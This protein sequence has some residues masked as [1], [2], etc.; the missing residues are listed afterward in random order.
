MEAR[1][2]RITRPDA[3]DAPSPPT[4]LRSPQA[5]PQ[6]DTQLS[7]SQMIDAVIQRFPPPIPVKEFQEELERTQRAYEALTS[8][9]RSTTARPTT[10]QATTESL[11]AITPHLDLLASPQH[12]TRRSTRL[13]SVRSKN[14]STTTGSS[15]PGKG[16]HTRTPRQGEGN[17][18]TPQGADP[19]SPG[20]PVPPGHGSSPDEPPAEPDSPQSQEFFSPRSSASLLTPQRGRNLQRIPTAHRQRTRDS[21]L[22]LNMPCLVPGCNTTIN[23]RTTLL[24]HL[25]DCHKGAD[26]DPQVKDSL[27]EYDIAK[28]E[29]LCQAYRSVN[30]NGTIHGHKCVPPNPPRPRNQKSAADPNRPIQIPIPRARAK[31]INPGDQN[32]PSK[33]QLVGRAICQRLGT[34]L[35]TDVP[36]DKVSLPIIEWRIL[37]A[38]SAQR[39]AESLPDPARQEE[40]LA[41][42]A[43]FVYLGFFSLK[44]AHMQLP[45]SLPNPFLMT[46]LQGPPHP[47]QTGNRQPISRLNGP[48]A[49]IQEVT[50]AA[51]LAAKGK[52]GAAAEALLGCLPA[53]TDDPTTRD[54]IRS[55]FPDRYSPENPDSAYSLPVIPAAPQPTGEEQQT[56]L[57]TT[58]NIIID[59]IH[60]R[61]LGSVGAWD[62]WTYDKLKIAVPKIPVTPDHP[63]IAFALLV[64]CLL[65]GHAQDTPIH[66]FLL[67]QRGVAL[68][69]GPS[70]A[71]GIRPICVVS[72][73]LRIC[74]HVLIA[75]HGRAL[76]SN[77][78][79]LDLGSSQGAGIEALP[80]GLQATLDLNPNTMII[81]LDITNAFNTLSREHLFTMIRTLHEENKLPA[82]FLFLPWFRFL[83]NPAQVVFP[84]NTPLT[85]SLCEGVPQGEPLSPYW[86]DLWISMALEPLRRAFHNRATIAGCHD[87]LF[88]TSSAPEVAV[89]LFLQVQQ[90]LARAHQ[91][92]NT[93]KCRVLLPANLDDDIAQLISINCDIPVQQFSR[94]GLVVA[95]TPIGSVPFIQDHINS[96]KDSIMT[97]CSKLSQAKT[98]LADPVSFRRGIPHHH[99]EMANAQGLIQ[100]LRLCIPSRFDL[101]LRTISVDHTTP[102]A[103]V[104][105]ECVRNTALTITDLDTSPDEDEK[106]T[107]HTLMALP[108]S[109]GGL[110][111]RSLT[112]TAAPASIASWAATGKTVIELFAL[113]LLSPQA[114]QAFLSWKSQVYALP[115]EDVGTLSIPEQDKR[116]MKEIT[117]LIRVVAHENVANRQM[118]LESVRLF[119]PYRPDAESNT[120]SDFPPKIQPACHAAGDLIGVLTGKGITHNGTRAIR[121]PKFHIKLQHQL[122]QAVYSLMQE[123]ISTTLGH[124]NQGIAFASHANR[125]SAAGFTA[126]PALPEHRMSD[127]VFNC[128]FATRGL[129]NL[130][131]PLT[132]G[133]EP[134]ACAAPLKASDSGACDTLCTINSLHCFHCSSPAVRGGRTAGH[135]HGKAAIEHVFSTSELR[136]LYSNSYH[137]QKREPHLS[138]FFS[139]SPTS[140]EPNVNTRADAIALLKSSL[141]APSGFLIDV[142]FVTPPSSPDYASSPS[143]PNGS[144]AATEAE[145][146]KLEHYKRRFDIPPNHRIQ[147]TPIALD[148]FGAAGEGTDKFISLIASQ[149]YP[150]TSYNKPSGEEAVRLNPLRAPFVKR[151][152]QTLAIG[153]FK[154]QAQS[155]YRWVTEGI[156]I[157][158]APKAST[159]AIGKRFFD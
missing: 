50:Q 31:K 73:L 138:Q 62:G 150:P 114:R 84:A 20:S 61:P 72:P 134:F 147:V 45:S 97:M 123:H 125:F 133:Q 107:S 70:P 126:S 71:D 18:R 100:V 142:T 151:L 47:Q 11:S 153:A 16:R 122:S 111:L 68:Q 28:C 76:A 137:G 139:R 25:N 136:R 19:S 24:A 65:R 69:K 159:N 22:Y 44:G 56:F 1:D 146:A 132:R 63:A 43:S 158:V 35:L 55:K 5:I 131:K 140:P 82:P 64:D 95:G 135:A 96:V 81:E 155:V 67:Q 144:K 33:R 119:S 51:V 14:H 128:V 9:S 92:L 75:I 23:D 157:S 59:Y 58:A 42:T 91:H 113:P 2:E 106:T 156:P 148:V 102:V 152:R 48:D 4:T 115:E 129:L 57:S 60:S 104:I 15:P 116:T 130:T 98:H 86:Y 34:P 118:L 32:K 90:T 36:A 89:E 145:K 6:D 29:G 87:G 37:V 30:A 53:D 124:S 108:A 26:T 109:R 17:G 121:S 46:P 80:R 74:S 127:A 143:N 10:P 79:P 13:S 83:M 54:T 40:A 49:V 39:I 110:G 52:P 66:H 3:E 12:G 93:K 78:N 88:I 103:S 27:K 77:I 38:S 21:A 112:I 99:L 117:R 105:D 7:F 149:A 120:V 94:T 41:A 154:R 101:L 85:V 8:L 141:G